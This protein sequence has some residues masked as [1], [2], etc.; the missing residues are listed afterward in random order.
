M[1]EIPD[2][3]LFGAHPKELGTFDADLLD[4]KLGYL[5]VRQF[6]KLTK[7]IKAGRNP[8]LIRH[9]QLDKKI[10]ET[11]KM[12]PNGLSPYSIGQVL[13]VEYSVVRYHLKKMLEDK[14]VTVEKTK[15]EAKRDKTTY[16]L[17]DNGTTQ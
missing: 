8:T 2:E 5:T 4:M 17:V 15:T 7:L 14:K 12:E 16:K 10:I 6:I 11:L 3:R 13:S 1:S 9:T